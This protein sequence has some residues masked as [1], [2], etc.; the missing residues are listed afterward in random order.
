[1]PNNGIGKFMRLFALSL[2]LILNSCS[3]YSVRVNDSLPFKSLYLNTVINESFAPNIHA[4]FQNQLRQTLLEQTPLTL[5]KT[6]DVADVQLD[7]RLVH[8]D[9]SARSR[10]S[11]DPGRFNALNLT[12]GVEL[13][14]Y[15]RKAGNYLIEKSTLLSSEPIFFDRTYNNSNLNEIEYE[16]LP[17]ISR[18]LAE[19][20]VNQILSYWD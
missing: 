15:D 20:V 4:L 7:L 10:S 19:S 2:I 6:A 8:Y 3:H 11:S 9:R 17:I 13:S 12:I 1:M 18:K 16:A 14:L 5:C